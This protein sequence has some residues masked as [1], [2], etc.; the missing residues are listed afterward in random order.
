MEIE[1][2]P[3]IDTVERL[4]TVIR[5]ARKQQ[6]LTQVE[7]AAKAGVSRQFVLEL[8]AGHPRA[9]LAKTLAVLS[10]LDLQPRAVPAHDQSLFDES[11]AFVGHR[12]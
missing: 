12:T 9:E 3:F 11:G 7:L 1:S 6:G 4:A 2:R 10:A 5:D 8:E